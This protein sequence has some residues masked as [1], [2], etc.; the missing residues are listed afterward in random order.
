[1]YKLRMPRSID[2]VC[3]KQEVLSERAD[4]LARRVTPPGEERER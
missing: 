4:R 1:M 2:F 3:L